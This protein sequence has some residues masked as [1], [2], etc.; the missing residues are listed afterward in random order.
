[1]VA[2]AWPTS[3]RIGTLEVLWQEVRSSLMVSDVA[4]ACPV[5][6]LPMI[7]IMMESWAKEGSCGL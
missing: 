1:M 6:R 2:L 5:V 4:Q 3:V 7:L